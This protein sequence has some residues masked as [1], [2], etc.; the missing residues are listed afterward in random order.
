MSGGPTPET[1]RAVL[2]NSLGEWT[3]HSW[4]ATERMTFTGA[5]GQPFVGWGFLFACE[6]TGAVRLWGYSK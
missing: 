1:T 6:S 2:V 4:V 3:P 5:G